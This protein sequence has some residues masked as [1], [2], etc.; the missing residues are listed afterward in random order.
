MTAWSAKVW[1]MAIWRFEKGCATRTMRYCELGV[2]DDLGLAFHF[3]ASQ[4]GQPPVMTGHDR[5]T[6]ILSLDEADSVLIDDATT[7]LIISSA[8]DHPLLSPDGPNW[9][10]GAAL[11]N[12]AAEADVLLPLQGVET[13]HGF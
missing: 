3:L 9:Y 8:D 6:I 10:R 11:C 4:P 13:S 1:S 7:P 12:E 5:G 2:G